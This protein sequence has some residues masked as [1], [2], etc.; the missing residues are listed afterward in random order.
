MKNYKSKSE[1]VIEEIL[2]ETSA[3]SAPTIKAPVIDNVLSYRR[4]NLCTPM[5][6][7]IFQLAPNVGGAQVTIIPVDH[8]DP[9]ASGPFPKEQN[10]QP[11]I[12][13]Q[14]ANEI[15]VNPLHTIRKMDFHITQG[16]K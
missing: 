2:G 11:P 15:P 1:K 13:Q 5:P 9:L 3:P 7:V 6:R 8:Q 16:V 4:T 14:Q 12:Q 10:V